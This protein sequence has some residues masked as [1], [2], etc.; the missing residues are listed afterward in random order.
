MRRKT[1]D[2]DGVTE[3]AQGGR[4]V[5]PVSADCRHRIAF[6]AHRVFSLDYL[7]SIVEHQYG[8]DSFSF[9]DDAGALF[10]NVELDESR[11]AENC[12]CHSSVLTM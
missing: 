11:I 12:G 1:Q 7:L 8:L 4:Q 9:L 5:L 3:V 2:R 10:E 6:A